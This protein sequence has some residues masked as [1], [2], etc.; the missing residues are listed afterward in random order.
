MTEPLKLNLPKEVKTDSAD[1]TKQF[2]N[3]YFSAPLAFSANEVD[4]VLGF[5][6]S[7]DF[8]KSAAQSIATV[9]MQQAKIDGVKVFELL[10]TLKG[11]NSIQLSNVVTEIMN[12]NREKISTIGYKIDEVADRTEARNILY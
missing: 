4:A 10:D 8:E 1:Q 2:F 11:L 9:L 7:R 3:Q 5:F 6:E 12:Y